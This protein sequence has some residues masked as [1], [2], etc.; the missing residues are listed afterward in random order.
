MGDT[1]KGEVPATAIGEESLLPVETEK[2]STSLSCCMY[3][4]KY[5]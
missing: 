3:Q 4:Y 5:P 2:T 1:T